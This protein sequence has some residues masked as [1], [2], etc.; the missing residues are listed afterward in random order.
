MTERVLF[1]LLMICNVLPAAHAE[2]EGFTYTCDNS[3]CFWRR[4]IVDPPPGW[5]R[6]EQSGAHFKFNAFVRKGETFTDSEVVM[7]ALAVSRKDAA[8]TLAEHINQNRDRHLKANPRSPVGKPTLTRNGDGKQL[9]TL[10]LTPGKPTGDWETVAFDEEGDY[11]LVFAL[12]ARTKA[13]H[14]KARNDFAA[15]VRGYR[16]VAKKP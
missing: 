13:A 7:Y 10:T 3:T 5:V 11:Y 15:F 6:D 9:T 12:S 8:P 16:K 1:A 14:D 2:T 4:P